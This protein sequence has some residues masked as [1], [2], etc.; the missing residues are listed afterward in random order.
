MKPVVLYGHYWE[1]LTWLYI[2]F[3]CCFTFAAS[4]S[5][6]FALAEFRARGT[7]GSMLLAQTGHTALEHPVKIGI[8]SRG[9]A[10]QKIEHAM[11]R[12]DSKETNDTADQ[13]RPSRC[14]NC[15]L[16][17]RNMQT[18]DNDGRRSRLKMWMGLMIRAEGT[19]EI[20]IRCS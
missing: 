9:S 7:L 20:R 14:A 11:P 13:G 8:R 17:A 3:E 4:G 18:L 6:V 10:K 12:V 16:W 19:I 1:T 15:A 5:I 2:S